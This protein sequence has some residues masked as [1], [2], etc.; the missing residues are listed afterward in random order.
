MARCVALY[1]YMAQ[2][3]E[4][5]TIRKNETLTVLSSDGSWWTVQNDSGKQGLVPSN[6]I[7]E[8][9]MV[10]QPPSFTP[11]PQPSF[12][13]APTGGGR[14]APY[15]PE[16]Y[17]QTDL[18][19]P[20]KSPALNIPAI[21]KFRYVSTREDELSLEKGDKVVI[22][23]KEADG[24]W[25]GRKDNHIGWFP[26]NYVEETGGPPVDPV[27]PTST[28]PLE[29]PFI[30]GVVALYSF[31]SGNP[32]ELAFNK[33]D[34]M[35]IIDQPPDDPDW[36]EARKPDGV[37]GLIPRNYVEVI[38]DTAPVFGKG[39]AG[40]VGPGGRGDGGIAIA[41]AGPLASGGGAKATGD[42]VVPPFVSEVWYHG[43]ISRKEADRLLEQTADNVGVF[44]VRA[45][46]TKVLRGGARNEVGGA[47]RYCTR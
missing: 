2:D 42:G 33:G 38:Q 36:W 12:S 17:Q 1:D 31:N 24:W 19:V 40:G 18:V 6:Y 3:S 15:K 44:L 47:D 35:D 32:E 29:K 22:L 37:T 5:L 26:F 16:M 45:S 11:S 9:P 7:K 10:Q 27:P 23:E 8:V 20:S 43:K 41:A 21:A 4:E 46:E 14:Q 30:C 13:M 25:R 28:S 39:T 34:L